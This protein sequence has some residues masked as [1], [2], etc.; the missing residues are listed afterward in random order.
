MS[1]VQ[2]AHV[3]MFSTGLASYIAARRV[4]ERH[5]GQRVV[6]LFADVK[7]HSASPHAGEDEDNYR[8]LAYASRDLTADGADVVHLRGTEDVWGVFRRRRRIGSAQVA[9]CSHELKQKP[10][11]A[12]LAEH[13]PQPAATT[14]HIGIDWSEAHR[15][16]AVERSYAPRPVGFPMTQPPYLDRHQMI[17]TCRGRGIEP[18]R[19]YGLGFPHANCGGFCVRAGH[20]Q[21]ALLLRVMPDRYAYH[22]AR[23][24]EMRDYLGTDV[25][26][27]RD[28]RDGVTRPI[29]L[30]AFRERLQAADA[31]DRLA[32]FDLDEWGGC[33]CFTADE[34]TVS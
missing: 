8:F 15:I 21:F 23:E 30:R 20:A 3:V 19:L 29:T 33:G 2:P 17:Q 34:V 18:P 27:L 6:A 26:I 11:H 24:Q 7:G 12:W 28:R 10:A 9:N 13:C 32:L 5:P 14:V 4:I 31:G 25:S 22:E 1:A 16:P